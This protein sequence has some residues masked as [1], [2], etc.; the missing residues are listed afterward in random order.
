MMHCRDRC[1][2]YGKNV[3]ETRI[4]KESKDNPF[5]SVNLGPF[6]PRGLSPG[7]AS[8]E[9]RLAEEFR[10]DVLSARA[11]VFNIQD[12][13]EEGARDRQWRHCR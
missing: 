10:G 8:E 6:S 2:N 1:Y 3:T 13:R 5:V 12:I 7:W 9:F 4:E 11:G